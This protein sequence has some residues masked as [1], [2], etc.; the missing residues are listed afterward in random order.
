M[1]VQVDGINEMVKILQLEI[2]EKSF[3]GN[4]LSQTGVHGI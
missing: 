4:V 2:L 1:R 3:N